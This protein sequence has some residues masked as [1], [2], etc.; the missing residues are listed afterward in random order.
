M[1]R[2]KTGTCGA[3]NFTGWLFILENVSSFHVQVYDI[4][5]AHTAWNNITK[6]ILFRGHKDETK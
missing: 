1:Y 3:E 2:N 5:C 4:M 6:A